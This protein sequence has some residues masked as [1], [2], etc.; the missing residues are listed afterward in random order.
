MTLLAKIILT[1]L[2]HINRHIDISLDQARFIY[3]LIE[4]Q[5][6]TKTFLQSLR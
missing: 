1:N 3:V 6:V 2:W 4:G 5:S